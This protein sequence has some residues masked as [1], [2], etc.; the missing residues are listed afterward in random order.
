[1]SIR[2]GK[3]SKSELPPEKE[4]VYSEVQRFNQWWIYALLGLVVIVEIVAMG[5]ALVQQLVHNKP[6]GTK[7]MSDAELISSAILAF[8]ALFL[9]IGV[10]LTCHLDLRIYTD[11]IYFRYFPFHWAYRKVSWNE[12]DSISCRTYKP[13]IEY[14]GWGIRWNFKS[15][16]Y[17]VRGNECIELRQGNARVILGTCQLQNVR[18]ALQSLAER[19][20]IP[21]QSVSD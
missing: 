5:N 15:W 1:M 12:L 18:S 3:V 19:F 13:L 7:P 8:I 4:L 17:T 11:G 16:A 20:S 9:A 6:W 14:G 10:I 21:L 2:F